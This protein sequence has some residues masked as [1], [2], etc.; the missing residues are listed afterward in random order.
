MSFNIGDR[1]RIIE[2]V[3]QD[4]FGNSNSEMPLYIGQEAVITEY[5]PS[6]ITVTGRETGVGYGLEAYFKRKVFFNTFFKSN[7]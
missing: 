4:Q 5:Y 6:Y 3:C 2:A 1:V 7:F